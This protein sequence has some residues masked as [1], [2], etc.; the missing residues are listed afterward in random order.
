MKTQ[1]KTL[2]GI[3]LAAAATAKL[4]VDTAG[5]MTL[6]A[7]H[8]Q[9]AELANR[10]ALDLHFF[11]GFDFANERSHFSQRQARDP[12]AARQGRRLSPGRTDRLQGFA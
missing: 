10:V 6:G 7:D 4:Q 2:L 9:T 8:V 11:A 1:E 5:L 3:A 12:T